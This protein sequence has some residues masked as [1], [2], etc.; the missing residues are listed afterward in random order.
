MDKINEMMAQGLYGAAKSELN[1]A[2]RCRRITIE[3]HMAKGAEIDALITATA[4]SKTVA[5]T[6]GTYN[7][8]N[9]SR[10]GKNGLGVERE[11]TEDF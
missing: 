6:R 10:V 4:T 1:V 2:L 7:P 5:P 8:L 9:W 3:Q 11:L